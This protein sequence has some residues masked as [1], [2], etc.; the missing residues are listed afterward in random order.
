MDYVFQCFGGAIGLMAIFFPITYSAMWKQY[1]LRPLGQAWR[2][3]SYCVLALTILNVFGFDRISMM[4]V[5]GIMIFFGLPI[6]LCSAILYVT[7][8]QQY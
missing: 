4:S 7:Y 5:P 1:Q 8:R 2:P 6:L 3:F